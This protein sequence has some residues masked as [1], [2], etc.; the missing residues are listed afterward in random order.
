MNVLGVDIGG[1]GIKGAPVD[2]EKG[3]LICERLRIPTPDPAK[4]QAV[5]EVVND[6]ARH[7][8]WQG[9][10][11]CTFPAVM[12]DGVAHTAANVDKEWIGT[13]A[14]A[15]ISE[16]T[17]N[18]AIVI[19]DADAAG[20][21]EME[22]GAGRHHQGVVMMLTFGAGIGTT[23]FVHGQLLP[24]TELGHLEMQGKEAE[25]RAAD[26]ARRR[27]NLSWEEW[28][29]RVNEYIEYLEALFWPDLFIIGG[30]VSNKPERFFHFLRSKVEMRS[31]QMR[32]DAGIIGAALAARTLFEPDAVELKHIRI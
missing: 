24:N 32:N 31:A 4:P 15:L 3:T 16:S 10:I 28:A 25:Y 1:T 12:K 7:F 6:I 18:P 21:A 5:A 23:F 26:S 30:G 27:K 8:N 13:N 22:F 14:A 9:P 17:G 20:I 19:N 11:G 29:E 2:T